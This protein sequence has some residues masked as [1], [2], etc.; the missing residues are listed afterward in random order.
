MMVLAEPY[1]GVASG[2]VGGLALGAALAVALAAF[3]LLIGLTST[4]GGGL[5]TGI[6][7]KNFMILLGVA[8]VLPLVFAGVGFAL[9][10]RS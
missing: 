8:A 9:G 7:N 2:W 4:A 5:L 3:T 6:G 1:D 10:K